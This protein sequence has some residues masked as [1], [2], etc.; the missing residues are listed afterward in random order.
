MIVLAQTRASLDSAV[1]VLDER[2]VHDLHDKKVYDVLTL[3]TSDAVFVNPD[4]QRVSGAGLRQLYD[5]VTK[6]FDSDLHLKREHL[7]RQGETAVE[8]GTYAETL[9]HRDTGK[10]DNVQGTYRFTLRREAD[11]SWLFSQ[12]EW[13]W[14]WSRTGRGPVGAGLRP[15]RGKWVQSQGWAQFR[16]D[17]QL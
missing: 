11:G 17:R 16:M 4:G 12:M 7:K 5:Q 13:H 14:D 15:V 8:D 6:A 9:G 2:F 10:V 1:N 3:Y